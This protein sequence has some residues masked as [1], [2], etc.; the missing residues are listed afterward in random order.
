MAK[1]KRNKDGTFKKK[2]KKKKRKKN[3][4]GGGGGGGGGKKKGRRRRRTSNPWGSRS[5]TIMG[6]LKDF[7]PR[8]FGKLWVVWAVRR[9]GAF[10]PWGTGSVIPGQPQLQSPFAGRSWTMGNYITGYIALKFAA[11]WLAR[12]RG[13]SYAHQFFQ[14][15]FDAL[16]TKLVWTE[17]FARVPWLQQQ[18]GAHQGNVMQTPDGQTWMMG[19]NGQWQALQGFGQVVQASPLDGMGQIVQASPLDGM[20]GTDGFG[21]IVHATALDGMGQAL[22]SSTPEDESRRLAYNM[23]GS[24]DPYASSYMGHADPYA[25]A[26]N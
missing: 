10:T 23:S 25:T 19:P 26:Y 22:P 11:Q 4:G 8:F 17:A 18:F 24:R 5:M 9:F 3:P 2:G 12:T 1:A 7:W 21:Q 13:G 14:G 15:G 16:A 6:G 20:G